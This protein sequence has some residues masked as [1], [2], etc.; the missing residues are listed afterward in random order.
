VWRGQVAAAV[1]VA[2]VGSVPVAG[3]RSASLEELAA[4]VDS[5]PCAACRRQQ[6]RLAGGGGGGG[7]HRN[8]LFTPD[9]ESHCAVALL[10]EYDTARVQRVTVGDGSSARAAAYAAPS[11]GKLITEQVILTSAARAREIKTQKFGLPKFSPSQ[12]AQGRKAGFARR[13]GTKPPS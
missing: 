13:F 1:A 3:S 5:E 12:T 4:V 10:L 7:L 8:Q 9:H 11:R 6:A 2:A